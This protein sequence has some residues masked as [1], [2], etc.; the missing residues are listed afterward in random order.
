MARAGFR[1]PYH[2]HTGEGRGAHDFSWSA[3]VLDRVET[4]WRL[5]GAGRDLKTKAW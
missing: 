4:S 5:A 2:P 1:E 3:L